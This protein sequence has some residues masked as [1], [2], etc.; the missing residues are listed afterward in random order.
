M[1]REV[2]KR[3]L[4]EAA[5]FKATWERHHGSLRQYHEAMGLEYDYALKLKHHSDPDPN[6][7]L[8][9]QPLTVATLDLY[10]IIRYEDGQIDNA[11]IY[12]DAR[13]LEP[14]RTPEE[15][16]ELDDSAAIFRSVMDQCVHDVDIGYPGVRRRVIRMSRAA[17]VGACRL[18]LM[19][20]GRGGMDVVPSVLDPRRISW[21]TRF[22]T[23]FDRGNNVLWIRHDRVPLDDLPEMCPGW[24]SCDKVAPDDGETA[25]KVED[26]KSPTLDPNKRAERTCTIVEGWIMEDEGEVEV[27]VGESKPL[28]PNEWYMGC[29]TCGYTER[30]LR[31][32][33]GYDGAMLPEFAP[34]PMCGPTPEG[35]PK[36]MMIRMETEREVGTVPEFEG[37]RRRVFFAPFS[38]QAG[39]HEEPWPKNLTHFPVMYHVSDPYP[40]EPTGNSQTYLNMDLQSLK[41]ASVVA[42][43]LQMER[44]RDLLLVKENAIFDAAHEPYQFDGSGDFVAYV[45]NYDDLQGMKHIQGQGLNS[46]FPTWMNVI[47]G[48]LSE[49]RGIGQ[50]SGT[51]EQLKGVQVGTIA[52]SIETGDVPLDQS[53]KIWREDEE[54]LF[55][56]WAEMLLGAWTTEQWVETAG[57]DGAVAMRAFR[58][59]D[60]PRMRLKIDAAPDL[61]AVDREILKAARELSEVKSPAL[62]RYAAKAAKLPK[63]VVDEL[64]AELTAMLAGTVPPTAGGGGAPAPSSAPGG[65]Y[66]ESPP[67]PTPVAPSVP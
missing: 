43:F 9:K 22:L 14:G 1:S 19:S 48:E 7:P 8:S 29:T 4:A 36:S 15:Q 53:L 40:L 10:D 47:S 39:Y 38:L 28:E 2:G 6:K 59:P 27:Q 23:P 49:H 58:A 30:D 11:A 20:N 66:V 5:D 35:P 56:R 34:C 31:E 18:D 46:A 55:N 21:D 63:S 16:K 44:N 42:G 12:L 24:K 67:M 41:D 51:A 37:K 26:F 61:N 50:A 57:M 62:L 65:G 45:G 33:P 17:R 54:R 64:V 3:K 60:M 25:Y 32:T 52:R 13:L